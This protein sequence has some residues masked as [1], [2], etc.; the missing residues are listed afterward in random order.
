VGVWGV[1]ARDEVV[2]RLRTTGRKQTAQ[3]VA[4]IGGEAD[5]AARKAEKSSGRWKK[6]GAVIGGAAIAAGTGL[7]KLSVD[8]F[9][10]YDAGLDAI[11]AGTGATGAQLDAFAGNMESV[12]KR[13][14]QP[15]DQVGQVLG[16]LNTR[17]G[18]IGAPL[19][20]LTEQ[21]LNLERVTGE[22]ASS[23]VP[24][25][26]RAFGDWALAVEDQSAAMDHL[27]RT[28]QATGQTVGALADQAVKYGAPMRQLGFT[29]ESTTALLGKFEKEGVNTELVMGGLR[30]SL[31]RIAK[32]GKDPQKVFTET[33]R[34][35]E[36]AGSAGEANALALELFGSRAG[37]DMAAAIREGRFSIGELMTSLNA[38]GDTINQTAAD[39]AD[40]AD[41]W[42]MLKNRA[43]PH[44]AEL[45]GRLSDLGVKVIEFTESDRVK[46]WADRAGEGLA[47]V[48]QNSSWLIPVVGGLAVALVAL[49]VINTVTAM[50]KAWRAVTATMTVTQWALNTALSANPIG[51]VIAVIA[52]LAAAFVI[53][54]KRSETFR[55][56]VDKAWGLLRK[57]VGFTPLGA[58]IGNFDRL[59]DSV[60]WVWD[61][62]KGLV[63]TIGKI[64]GAGLVS[65]IFG[66]GPEGRAV[67]GPVRSFEPYIVG[68][69]G[70]ELFVPRVSGDVVTAR[71]TRALMAAQATAGSNQS[72]GVPL[73]R[74]VILQPGAV[75]IHESGDPRRSLAAV[76]QALRDAEADL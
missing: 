73:T 8:A 50:V 15:L 40:F 19:E 41:K 29:F 48:R 52:G 70:P 44:L 14:T 59:R 11:R 2:V 18:Q 24:G 3:D 53:A 37:P 68:E 65:R 54:Y 64:P 62:A 69:R 27:F 67:G 34:A 12:G 47:W 20:A 76:R 5:K 39:T 6:W 4:S 58:L 23:T 38:S 21:F 61:K 42:A 35:I 75:V 26:T 71:E 49:K 45:G 51:L 74:Q 46:A 56:I 63:E 7:V 33:M 1:A 17:T 22:A 32:A 36:G 28:S 66:G 60:G 55:G 30:Q 16:D 9:A 31:G 25:V 72:S 57:F 10:T 43:T 13:V